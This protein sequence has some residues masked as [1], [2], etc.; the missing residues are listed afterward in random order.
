MGRANASTVLFLA[1][2]FPFGLYLW[3]R[4]R[5]VRALTVQARLDEDDHENNK[6]SRVRGSEL[7][8]MPCGE[9][10]TFNQPKRSVR[11]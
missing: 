1:V 8:R 5:L 10:L 9:Q 6:V 11:L 3:V 2:V 4:L 7:T